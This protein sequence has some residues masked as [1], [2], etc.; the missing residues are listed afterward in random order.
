MPHPPSPPAAAAD[1][2]APEPPGN[3]A[4]GIVASNSMATDKF[5]SPQKIGSDDSLQLPSAGH[6]GG[7]QQM[8]PS[9]GDS[10]R[11]RMQS[12]ERLAD[13]RSIRSTSIVSGGTAGGGDRKEDMEN[14]V[15]LLQ[16]GD[17]LSSTKGHMKNVD[18][19]GTALAAEE[20][21][22]AAAAVLCSPP[23]GRLAMTPASVCPSATVPGG[24]EGAEDDEIMEDVSQD[25]SGDKGDSGS[26]FRSIGDLPDI[27]LKQEVRDFLR[28]L[29]AASTAFCFH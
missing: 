9:L 22:A 3:G 6:L 1:G 29:L 24:G 20:A 11:F 5:Y 12:A 27:S 7:P 19:W 8:Q 4:Q 10:L 25:G 18:S 13:T 28:G 17:K 16:K 15:V 14:L 23:S 26:N 21:A 2:K